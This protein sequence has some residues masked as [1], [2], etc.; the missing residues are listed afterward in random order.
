MTDEKPD[1][2]TPAEPNRVKRTDAG[3]R[4]DV[5]PAEV[6]PDDDGKREDEAPKRVRRRG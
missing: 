4:L 1:K 3:G 5:D 2:P 6:F